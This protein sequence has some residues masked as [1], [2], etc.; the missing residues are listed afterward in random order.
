MAKK[1]GVIGCPKL[2]KINLVFFVFFVI[3]FGTF[4][5]SAA[6]I[7]D[8]LH[9]NIQTTDISGNVVTGTFSFV[10]NISTTSDCLNVV[11]SNSTSLTTDSRGI[12]SYYLQNTGLSY[13]SQYYLC[14]Y[15]NGV[16][17][18][19][20]KIAR[21]PYSFTAQNTTLSGMSI[22]TNLNMGS[23]NATATY[24]FGSGRYLTDIDTSALN[25]SQVNYWNKS[26]N[27]L[28]YNFGNV[29]IGTTAPSQKLT[30]T[31]TGT[32]VF[33]VNGDSFPVGRFVRTVTNAGNFASTFNLVTDYAGGAGTTGLG[34]GIVFSMRDNSTTDD[35]GLLGSVGAIREDA[36]NTGSLVF[37]TYAAG[38]PNVQMTILSTGNVGIGT[39]APASKL[40]VNGTILPN[41]NDNFYLGSS[42]KQWYRIYAGSGGLNSYG[43]INQTNSAVNNYFA[44]NVGIGIITPSAK[45]N[46]EGGDFKVTNVGSAGANRTISVSNVYSGSGW[47]ATLGT[48]QVYGSYLSSISGDSFR[49]MDGTDTNIYVG[50]TGNVG[51]GT[52]APGAKLDINGSAI[53][54]QSNA[55]LYFQDSTNYIHAITDNF[56]EMRSTGTSTDIGLSSN[57]G[58]SLISDRDQSG[59]GD[60]S[61]SPNYTTKMIITHGGNVGIGTTA[62][63]NKLNVIGD[64]NFTGVLY[65][66]GQLVGSGTLNSTGWNST[67]AKVF[68]ANTS[69]YVGIGTTSPDQKLHLVGNMVVESGNTYFTTAG[70]GVIFGGTSAY[71]LIKGSA[72]KELIFNTNSSERMRIDSSGNVG[73]GTTIPGAK[74]DV[75]NGTIW[76]H[77][78]S[79]DYQDNL[80]LGNQMDSPNSPLF[81]I[82][83]DDVDS[84]LLEIQSTRYLSEILYTASSPT[85]K[86]TAATSNWH[87]TTGS[88]I[89]YYGNYTE[90]TTKIQ[91]KTNGNSYFN[92]GNVGIGT[93]SPGALLELSKNGSSSLRLTNTLYT[94]SKSFD[95]GVLDSGGLYIQNGTSRI[96]QVTSNGGFAFG[97]YASGA[98]SPPVGGAIISGNVGIGTTSPTQKLE[99]SGNANFTGSVIIGSAN[100]TTQSNGD[101]D[102]W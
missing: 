55:F 27:D 69:A 92:G 64:G 70:N 5:V 94:P 95:I 50:G 63:A 74:L 37:R 20:A 2:N 78:S 93:T 4:F 25:L 40:D 36:D 28:Y 71:G 26:G 10:F 83:T 81:K 47:T 24:Y 12:I 21:T 86:A 75:V 73:I 15:R 6:S 102:V 58:I 82:S 90:N 56:F 101:V 31:G 48:S 43:A 32:N 1:R 91:F 14:Y 18:D 35:S 66:N 59:S 60:I 51:I 8:Q 45:L 99:V 19:N 39:T 96:L 100:I 85:G 13:D 34:G 52:T 77:S 16:L 79:G 76:A 44:G 7:L 46:V 11:Y 87:Y 67:G 49:I 61:F 53:L 88:T 89:S 68:L 23:Y 72:S 54:S 30:V 29:G 84:D 42:T 97:N 33:Q 41:E 80:Y 3:V 17:I 22:D 57:R 98:Y 62:P 38:S 65:S 9:L